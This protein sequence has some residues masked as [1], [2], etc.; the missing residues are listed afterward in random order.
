MALSAHI[1]ATLLLVAP[2]TKA[3]SPLSTELTLSPASLTIG[4]VLKLTANA[5]PAKLL[6]ETP[7]VLP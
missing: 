3:S 7:V 6:P 4:R 1:L 2:C 5:L